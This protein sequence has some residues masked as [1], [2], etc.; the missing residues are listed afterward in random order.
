MSA[1]HCILHLPIK[2]I[3]SDNHTHRSLPVLT[4]LYHLLKDSVV[5]D[6]YKEENQLLGL[7][8]LNMSIWVSASWS[9]SLSVCQSIGQS[10]GLSVNLSV[11][12]SVCLGNDLEMCYFREKLFFISLY[13][14]SRSVIST[15]FTDFLDSVSIST[16]F[17]RNLSCGVNKNFDKEINNSISI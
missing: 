2:I 12:W 10:V 6:L 1:I 3:A 9:V 17:L 8:S 4:L 13:L 7:V 15:T 5:W 16:S 11:C 14:L